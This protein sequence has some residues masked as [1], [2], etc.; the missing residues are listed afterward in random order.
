[1]L[2]EDGEGRLVHKDLPPQLARLNI[3]PYD[4]KT[5]KGLN[6]AAPNETTLK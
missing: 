6:L 2:K 4:E 1:M 3:G 5:T